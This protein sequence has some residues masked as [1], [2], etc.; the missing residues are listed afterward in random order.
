MTFSLDCCSE[1]SDTRD[2]QY[3]MDH[4]SVLKLGS[5]SPVYNIFGSS[6]LCI[7]SIQSPVTYR[8]FMLYKDI[9]LLEGVASLVC[10]LN[11]QVEAKYLLP[12]NALSQGFKAPQVAFCVREE[13]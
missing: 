13:S 2:S 1:E 8:R 6:G 9:T 4:S 5:C 11:K 10:A 7:N 12:I 3:F